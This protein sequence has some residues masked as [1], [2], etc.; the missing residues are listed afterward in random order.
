M[1]W[2]FTEEVAVYIHRVWPLLAADPVEHIVALTVID[3]LR[4]GQRWSAE[5]LVLGWYQQGS[6]VSGAVLCTPPFELVLAVVP[7]GAVGE[8]VTTLRA[9]QIPVPGVN[10]DTDLVDSFVKRWIAAT[11][12]HAGARMHRQLYALGTLQPPTPLPAGGARLAS[13]DDFALVLGWFVAFHHEIGGRGLG[14][15]RTVGT[16]I[17]QELVWLWHDPTGVVVSLAGR[18][19]TVAGVAH[20]APVYTPLR[21]RRC[22]YGAAITA[23]CTQDALRRGAQHV[24]L[25]TDLTNP[26]SNTLYQR[27]GYQPVRDRT[28]VQFA[29]S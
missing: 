16:R 21:H 2:A 6:V 1:G 9:R 25:L 17:D 14:L 5:P 13:S 7:D 18:S 4:G 23:A 19:P 10:G 24:A 20:L 15:E 28:I 8:L 29:S 27:L 26:V 12:G 3:R 11:S 22:G